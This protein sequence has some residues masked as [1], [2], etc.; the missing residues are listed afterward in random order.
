MSRKFFCAALVLSLAIALPVL[1]ASGTQAEEAIANF[2]ALA[3]PSEA[4]A[5]LDYF[6]GSWNTQTTFTYRGMAKMDVEGTIETNWILGG[7][8]LESHEYST[9]M[10]RPYEAQTLL[11]YDNATGKLTQTR[12]DNQATFSQNFTGSQSS[13]GKVLETTTT[14]TD[15]NTGDTTVQTFTTTVVDADTY[16]VIGVCEYPDGTAQQVMQM[17]ATRQ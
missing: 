12:V 10:D 13:D 9:F 2:E 17:T 8:F 15:P 14:F 6:V 16:T 3:E 5:N 4:H 1:A 11:G 7:R